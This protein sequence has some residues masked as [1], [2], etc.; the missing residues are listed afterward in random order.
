MLPNPFS[1]PIFFFFFFWSLSLCSESIWSSL[2]SWQHWVSAYIRLLFSFLFLPKLGLLWLHG[3][4]PHPPT[5]PLSLSLFYP[6]VTFTAKHNIVQRQQQQNLHN[7]PQRRGVRAEVQKKTVWGTQNNGER[8]RRGSGDRRVWRCHSQPEVRAAI[9]FCGPID[10]HVVP[11][12]S[13]PAG[14][15]PPC[16]ATRHLRP[17]LT[18]SG[19]SALPAGWE[20]IVWIE[21][22]RGNGG[23]GGGGGVE[24]AYVVRAN[25]FP[26]FHECC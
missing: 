15:A 12:L 20:K 2:L 21:V 7:Y 16:P 14:P 26:Y 1:W 17:W 13:R 6:T 11:H 8:L 3:P 19:V 10:W 25:S 4:P 23:G 9:D 24:A 5:H 18:T 22:C